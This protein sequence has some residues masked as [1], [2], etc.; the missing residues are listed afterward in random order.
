MVEL[1]VHSSFKSIISAI[2]VTKS[3]YSILNVKYCE[4]IPYTFIHLS[5]FRS[6]MIVVL[7][8]FCSTYLFY[9]YYFLHLFLHF[10][11]EF[12]HGSFI[13][14]HFETQYIFL[15]HITTSLIQIFFGRFVSLYFSR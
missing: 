12:F 6:F 1:K 8:V 11:C 14:F 3:Y 7:E 4:N 13:I 9:L 15:F 10:S 5:I 2:K